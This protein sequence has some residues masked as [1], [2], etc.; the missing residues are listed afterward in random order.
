MGHEER[1]IAQIAQLAASSFREHQLELTRDDGLFRSWR[2]GKPGCCNYAFKVVTFPGTLLV[3]GDLGTLVV[4][5]TDDMIDWAR[6][7]IRSLGYFAEKVIPEIT[8]REFSPEVTI[9]SLQRLEE[10]WYNGEMPEDMDEEVTLL[11]VDLKNGEIGQ[12]EVLRRLD[13]AGVS[14]AWELS[15]TCYK[16]RFLW[17]VEA[18]KW[19]YSQL[20]KGAAHVSGQ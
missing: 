3:T 15:M 2:C 16:S 17:Q 18:L 19:F 20:D 12:D 11:I 8:T 1:K 7:A 14:D 13:D 10:D 4:Q 5:R 9:E 6:S